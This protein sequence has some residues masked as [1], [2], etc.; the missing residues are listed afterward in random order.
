M[1][2]RF[3][4]RKI[5][6]AF[7]LALALLAAAPLSAGAQEAINSVYQLNG[8]WKDAEGKEINLGDELKGNPVVVSMAYTKCTYTCPLIVKKLKEIEAALGKNPKLRILLISFDTKN[9]TPATMAAFMK[10][11]GLDPG[12][13]K[14]VTGKT[15][16]S[17]REMAALL[18]VNYK[19]EA[20]GHFS[21]SNVITLLDKDGVIRASLKGIAADHAPLVRE[22]KKSL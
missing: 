6:I 5:A 8:K 20:N 13:W 11:K 16:G 4:L 1:E 18:E 19:E 14:M 7:S 10:E 17:V 22:A 2:S 15:S 9:E 3:S 12:R 21:H